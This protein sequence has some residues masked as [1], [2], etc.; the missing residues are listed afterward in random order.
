MRRLGTCQGRYFPL[1]FISV[2][3][4]F[5][6]HPG[7]TLS[8]SSTVQSAQ[9][10]SSARLWYRIPFFQYNSN[11]RN[12]APAVSHRREAAFVSN[13][14][15]PLVAGAGQAP[16]GPPGAP[17]PAMPA[18]NPAGMVRDAMHCSL[19]KRG[20]L[21]R[22]GVLLTRRPLNPFVESPHLCAANSS[23]QICL[24]ERCLRC[25]RGC[26][27]RVRTVYSSFSRFA[28]RAR[29]ESKHG[30]S[31]NFASCLTVSMRCLASRPQTQ[32]S[33]GSRSRGPRQAF[34]RRW[35]ATLRNKASRRCA[36]CQNSFP[37]ARIHLV[38][39]QKKSASGKPLSCVPL[40]LL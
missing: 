4:A 32:A 28:A 34:L 2:I 16:P 35:A 31:V 1:R 33:Q 20:V 22:G 9:T 37:N 19:L 29:R 11:W 12:D 21:R 6:M 14:C 36:F 8:E 5:R 15:T 40:V 30:H 26:P 25:R 38:L 27:C 3:F 24:H 7:Q 39:L 18:G 17:N 23:T 13:C 10:Q